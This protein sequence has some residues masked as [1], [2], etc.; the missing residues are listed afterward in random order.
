MNECYLTLNNN[1]QLGCGCER[2]TVTSKINTEFGVKSVIILHFCG[3][4]GTTLCNIS[5]IQGLGPEPIDS[6]IRWLLMPF[7]K[8]FMLQN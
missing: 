1:A 8:A 4:S 2:S 5:V 7:L 3:C 6:E